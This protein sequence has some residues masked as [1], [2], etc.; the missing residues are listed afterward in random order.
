MGR[1]VADWK[2]PSK[3]DLQVLSKKRKLHANSAGFVHK[4]PIV[5]GDSLTD[6]PELC[7]RR[8]SFSVELQHSNVNGFTN[9]CHLLKT[10]TV[11]CQGSIH[12]IILT[13]LALYVADYNLQQVKCCTVVDSHAVNKSVLLPANS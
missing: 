12:N 2:A 13:T 1:F 7:L 8:V 10:R 5:P 6:L 11:S 9:G 3:N 4:F